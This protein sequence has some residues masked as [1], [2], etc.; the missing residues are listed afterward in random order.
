MSD[1]TRSGTPTSDLVI[2]TIFWSDWHETEPW[3]GGPGPECL[4]NM[5]FRGNYGHIQGQIWA[6][7]TTFWP[8]LTLPQAP[9]LTICSDCAPKSAILLENQSKTVKYAVKLV[10]YHM[11][12][13]VMQSHGG[14]YPVL[15]C[16]RD[17]LASS[18][19]PRAGTSIFYREVARLTRKW[20]N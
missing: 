1:M 2:F 9:W 20:L 10:D 8:D 6:S 4:E 11:P 18:V 17:I 12:Q 7:F 5:V 19:S 13:R 14:I 3:A 16:F 15:P